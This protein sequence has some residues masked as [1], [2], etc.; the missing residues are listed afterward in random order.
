MAKMNGKVAK[1]SAGASE[2]ARIAQVVNITRSLEA[3]KKRN[4]WIAL[5]FL[6]AALV[7]G[8]L[9]LGAPAEA[10]ALVFAGLAVAT[11]AQSV[12]ARRVRSSSGSTR[13]PGP[14]A[15]EVP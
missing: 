6:P 4:I 11:L 3:M 2:H 14:G 13:R 9:R 12:A 10:L 15:T 7:N 1:T 8:E 5:L